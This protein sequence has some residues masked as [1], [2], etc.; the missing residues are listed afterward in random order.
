MNEGTG[1][2]RRSGDALMADTYDRWFDTRW[3]SYAFTI[4]RAAVLAALPPL[5]GHRVL[6]AG[7]GTGRFTAAIEAAGAEVTG[8]D[9]DPAMLHL[10]RRRTRG[11]LL[12]GDAHALPFDDHTFDIA[13]AI[14][15]LEFADRAHR[16]IEELVRVTRPGGRIAVATIN[17][18]SPWGIVHRHELRRLPWTEAG[19]RTPDEL[20]ALLAGHGRVR[21]HAALYAPAAVPGLTRVGPVIERL[22]HPFPRYGAFQVA[23]LDLPPVG[24][25]NRRNSNLP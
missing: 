25:A 20:R 3:G 21:L 16:V 22:G 11:V 14:T 9:R 18:Q 10:A 2:G 1:D 17:P 8:L 5:A 23:T 13:V 19:L 15:L 7:C 6:D 24:P 4:E 12:R